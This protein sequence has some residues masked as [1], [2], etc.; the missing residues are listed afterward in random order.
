MNE[1]TDLGE[2]IAAKGKAPSIPIDSRGIAR[3]IGGAVYAQIG[4]GAAFPCATTV[5]VSDGDEVMIRFENHSAVI[6]GN[7]GSPAV[8]KAEGE[9]IRSIA[10][11]AADISGASYIDQTDRGLEIGNKDAGGRWTGLRLIASGDAVYVV[12]A[13]GDVVAAYG[14]DSVVLGKECFIDTVGVSEQGGRIMNLYAPG[15]LILGTQNVGIAGSSMSGAF[16]DIDGGSVEISVIDTSGGDISGKRN[17]IS[18]R[19][20]GIHLDG[21]IYKNGRKLEW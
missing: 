9:M 14:D 1:L 15:G 2:E 10:Q 18:L 7:L 11:H 8:S 4:G 21:D 20:D 16:I 5:G 17:S 3:I 12:D 13:G 19:G 6:T